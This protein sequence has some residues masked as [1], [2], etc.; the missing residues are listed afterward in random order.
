LMRVKLKT[1]LVLRPLI[2]ANCMFL[3]SSLWGFEF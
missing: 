3:G 1:V 2:V